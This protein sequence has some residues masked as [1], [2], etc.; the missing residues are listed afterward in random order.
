MRKKDLLADIKSHP[1]TSETDDNNLK[2]LRQEANFYFL[3]S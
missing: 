1:L 3:E 2:Q